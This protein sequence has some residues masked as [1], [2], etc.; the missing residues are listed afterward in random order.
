M[1][2]PPLTLGDR[3]RGARTWR[4]LSQF[5][6]ADILGIARTSVSRYELGTSIPSKLVLAAWADACDVD[7]EWL[8]SGSW[9]NDPHADWSREES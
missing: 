7:I 3:L 1:N 4:E 8:R 6:L 2:I 5:E 9:P